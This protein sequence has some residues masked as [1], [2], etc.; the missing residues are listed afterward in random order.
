MTAPPLVGCVV[1]SHTQAIIQSSPDHCFDVLQLQDF[2]L[3]TYS[4]TIHVHT[5]YQPFKLV[6]AP[7]YFYKAYIFYLVYHFLTSNPFFNDETGTTRPPFSPPLYWQQT[8]NNPPLT[9][10]LYSSP[11][12]PV[13]F[14]AQISQLHLSIQSII[15]DCL[16]LD[17]IFLTFHTQLR[18]FSSLLPY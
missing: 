11:V 16:C 1:W 7:S 14:T 6:V 4:F 15:S 17:L 5:S 18:Y 3:F 9:S 13:S 12:R 8:M 2:L 10:I